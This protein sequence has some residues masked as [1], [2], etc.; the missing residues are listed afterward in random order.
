VKHT[1]LEL[2]AADERLHVA[3]EVCT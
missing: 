2:N 3:G 1:R